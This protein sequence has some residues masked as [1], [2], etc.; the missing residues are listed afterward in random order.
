[1][2]EGVKRHKVPEPS[3]NSSEV[4]C[5]NRRNLDDPGG[6]N[7]NPQTGKYLREGKLLV[8]GMFHS[9]V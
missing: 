5:K 2:P 8:S 3:Y 6:K 7:V 1:M 9:E 4:I